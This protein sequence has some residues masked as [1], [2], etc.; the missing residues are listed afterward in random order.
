[1]TVKTKVTTLETRQ[2]ELEKAGCWFQT[3]NEDGFILFRTKDDKPF[4]KKSIK[5]GTSFI[6]SKG[7][8]W[9]VVV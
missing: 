2:P 9:K 7:I 3:L 6:Y 4:K 1:M 8:L 5:N